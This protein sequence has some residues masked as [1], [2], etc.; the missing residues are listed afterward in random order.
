LHEA[1]ID[2]CVRAVTKIK[3][4]SIVPKVFDAVAFSK[5]FP[6]TEVRFFILAECFFPIAVLSIRIE[7]D[8]NSCLGHQHSS[9]LSVPTRSG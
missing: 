8:G 1:K 9:M 2:D 3:K 7:H 6:H 4:K 5:A